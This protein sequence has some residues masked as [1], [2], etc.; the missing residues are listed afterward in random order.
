MAS[1]ISEL[2]LSDLGD[3][4]EM[5]S[6]SADEQNIEKKARRASVRSPLRS[7]RRLVPTGVLIVAWRSADSTLLVEDTVTAVV[8]I[9]GKVRGTLSVSAKITADELEALARGDEKVQRALG[10]KE[11]ARAVVRAPKVVSF[12]TA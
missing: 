2:K 7:A 4:D 11:I 9:N 5:R 3:G 1:A 10:G 12:T 8:Q 6:I